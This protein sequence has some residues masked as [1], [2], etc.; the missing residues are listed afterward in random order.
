M[1]STKGYA[2]INYVPARTADQIYTIEV[3]D[4]AP[5]V[6]SSDPINNC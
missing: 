1:E 2:Y 4:G 5:H 3:V 6:S